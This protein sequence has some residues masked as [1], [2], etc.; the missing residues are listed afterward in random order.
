MRY[1]GFV[2]LCVALIGC[3]QEESDTSSLSLNTSMDRPIAK[4][5]FS[6]PY[7]DSISIAYVGNGIDDEGTEMNAGSFSA[8]DADGWQIYITGNVWS[9]KGG[10]SVQRQVWM[11]SFMRGLKLAREAAD[12]DFETNF[13]QI[14]FVPRS[15]KSGPTV[16]GWLGFKPDN[17]RNCRA[18]FKRCA[19][20]Y[21]ISPYTRHNMDGYLSQRE[22][23]SPYLKRVEED[24]SNG[25]RMSYL[26]SLGFSDENSSYW[27]KV[28]MNAFIVDPDGYVADAVIPLASGRELSPRTVIKSFMALQGMAYEEKD[29]SHIEEMSI[30]IGNRTQFGGST[31]Q[32]LAEE[33]A[34]ILSGD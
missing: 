11:S 34:D 23:L 8:E 27:D 19:D 2:F 26:K 22:W 7:S 32:I 10:N 17:S 30:N 14:D 28:P 31:G 20:R 1:L 25:G 9:D 18:F 5:A 33:L 3:G 13:V 15:R 12:L 29:F 16:N 6:L 21:I 24:I 4:T